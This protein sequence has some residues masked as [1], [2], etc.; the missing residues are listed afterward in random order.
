MTTVTWRV[1]RIAEHKDTRGFII[2]SIVVYLLAFIVGICVDLS[3]N[4]GKYNFGQI[5]FILYAA[6]PYLTVPFV[7]TL[8]CVEMQKVVFYSIVACASVAAAAYLGALYLI[9]YQKEVFG[10]G[11]VAELLKF[12]IAFLPMML[13]KV[14][15]SSSLVFYGFLTGSAWGV[16][17]NVILLVS[18]VTLVM[19]ASALTE[20]CW[21]LVPVICVAILRAQQ[22]GKFSGWELLAYAT[23]GVSIVLHGFRSMLIRNINDCL[24][25]KYDGDCESDS[26]GLVWI[27]LGSLMLPLLLLIPLILYKRLED[28]VVQEEPKCV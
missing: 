14:S 7:S 16:L 19:P 15:D 20:A 21:T 27:E 26:Y 4:R 12:V 5:G 9:P 17:V 8:L 11:V 13:G 18:H 1:A 23:V 22:K 10:F 28:E 3:F 6:I 25:Y 2:S 24:F